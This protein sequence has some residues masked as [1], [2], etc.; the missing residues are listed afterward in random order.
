MAESVLPQHTFSANIFYELASEEASLWSFLAGGYCI[1]VSRG[2]A[3]ILGFD[4]ASRRVTVDFSGTLGFFQDDM[5]GND[6][7]IKSI[8][9]PHLSDESLRIISA[10][11]D[12]VKAMREARYRST[13]LTKNEWE[14][15]TSS[16]REV[17]AF[18]H[19]RFAKATGD[20]WEAVLACKDWRKCDQPK[21]GAA[22]NRRVCSLR[23]SHRTS[24][25]Y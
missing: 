17:A 14:W 9:L 1:H 19:E 20:V 3:K 25:D 13:V 2:K 16:Q 8:D 10:T 21:K 12:R 5:F 24:L 6:A 23:E 15:L 11:A 7:L 4:A 18:S 22:R